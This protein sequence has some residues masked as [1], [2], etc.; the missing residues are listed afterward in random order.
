MQKTR[1][2]SDSLGEIQ[3]P[4]NRYW[5][6]QTQRSLHY[7]SIGED[8]LPLEVVRALALAKI[9]AARANQRLGK[10]TEEE[11]RLIEAAAQEV[12]DGRLDEHFPL[13]VWMRSRPEYA[14]R[15]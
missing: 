7:F 9:A 10:L 2:E 6:A 3:V 15:P 13:R 8:L 4:A 5:G 14:I 1:T 12:A 11:A